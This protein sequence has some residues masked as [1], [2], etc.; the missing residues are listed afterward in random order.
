MASRF[1]SKHV[2]FKLTVNSDLMRSN[3]K[4]EW[5]SGDELGFMFSHLS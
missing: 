5:N 2:D 3:F 1:S 4:P